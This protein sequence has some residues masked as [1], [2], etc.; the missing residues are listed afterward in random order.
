MAIKK[1]ACDRRLDALRNMLASQK[2]HV[3]FLM[4]ALLY[5][6]HLLAANF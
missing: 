1:L 4:V 6:G 5:L 2:L 3:A